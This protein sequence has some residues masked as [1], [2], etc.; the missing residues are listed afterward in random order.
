MFYMA[1]LQR[2]MDSD[3]GRGATVENA[4]VSP[5]YAPE[6]DAK[7]FGVQLADLI[8]EDLANEKR[9][10]SKKSGKAARSS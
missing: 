9:P 10:R 3:F 4:S 5:S 6:P 7:T 2:L 8:K 1:M